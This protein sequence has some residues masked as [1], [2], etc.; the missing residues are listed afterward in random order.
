ME[1][2][3][4]L[5]CSYIKMYRLY[6]GFDLIEEDRKKCSVFITT[7]YSKEG[8]LFKS[9]QRQQSILQSCFATQK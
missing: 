8:G 6:A 7:W 4:F 9:S 2:E 1:G 5:C 3:F